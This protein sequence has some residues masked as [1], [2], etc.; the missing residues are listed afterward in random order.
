M[1]LGR[2]ITLPRFPLRV[3]YPD[4]GPLRSKSGDRTCERS[5]SPASLRWVPNVQTQGRTGTQNT[6]NLWMTGVADR[7]L[8]QARFRETLVVAQF[9]V[10]DMSLKGSLLEVPKAKGG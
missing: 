7:R 5:F 1:L 4:L 9:C 10:G 6:A 2:G 8:S 3:L